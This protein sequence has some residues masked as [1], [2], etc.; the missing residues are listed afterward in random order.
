MEQQIISIPVSYFSIIIPVLYIVIS[1]GVNYGVIKVT[2]NGTK[3][4]LEETKD[5]ILLIQKDIN[6]IGEK[7]SKN[8]IDIR[9]LKVQKEEHEKTLAKLEKKLDK[10]IENKFGLNPRKE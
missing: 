8:T 4:G 6:G 2:L 9:V 7:I 1:V 5:S 3:K 10:K